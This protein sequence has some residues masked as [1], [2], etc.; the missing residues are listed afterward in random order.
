[1]YACYFYKFA[2]SLCFRLGS[3]NSKKIDGATSE[4][5]YPRSKGVSSPHPFPA[6]VRSQPQ[7]QTNPWNSSLLSEEDKEKKLTVLFE[8]TGVAQDTND[9]H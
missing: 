3:Y 4:G 5:V 8:T 7:G 9:L 6:P 1:L 2:A